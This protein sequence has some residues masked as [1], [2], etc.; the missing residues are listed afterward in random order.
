[1]WL[2]KLIKDRLLV[3]VLHLVAAFEQGRD[4]HTKERGDLQQSATADAIGPF[5]VFLDLLEC[6]LELI[7]K[8]GL[9]ESPLQTI[10]L[11]IAADDPVDRVKVLCGSS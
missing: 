5:L 9:R 3:S 7:G 4:W 2:R 6:Q 1:M 10:D 8:L 11:D